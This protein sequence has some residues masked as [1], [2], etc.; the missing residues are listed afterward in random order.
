M[1]AVKIIL[2]GVQM[3]LCVAIIV[4]NGIEVCRIATNEDD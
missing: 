3:A 2:K 4:L 1:K